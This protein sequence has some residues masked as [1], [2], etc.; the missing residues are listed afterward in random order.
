VTDLR[1]LLLGYLGYFLFPLWLVA[2]IA[3]YLCHR[4]TRIESTSGRKESLLHVL[5]GVEFGLPLLAG[6]FLEI[7]ALVLGMMIV[8]ALA[9]SVT[10]YWDVAYT[11]PRRHISPFEQHV[12]SVLLIVPVVAVAI[13][14]L[15]YWEQFLAIFGSGT[16]SASLA[17]QPKSE[18][19]PAWQIAAVLGL[20]LVLQALPLA[21]ECWRTW[22][23][24]QTK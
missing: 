18:S 15:L 9:H 3:D 6:L 16:T 14:A 4:R 10:S 24:R 23:A 12:H 19:L 20:V 22:H 1:G 17:L 7:N 5:L 21:E 13:V 8:A 2:G 11:A